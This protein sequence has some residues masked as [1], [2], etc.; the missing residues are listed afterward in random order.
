[1]QEWYLRSRPD[2]ARSGAY[3][4]HGDA[5]ARGAGLRPYLLGCRDKIATAK[6]RRTEAERL[7]HRGDRE[8]LDRRAIDEHGEDCAR[9]QTPE[10]NRI[11]ELR[12]RTIQR[13]RNDRHSHPPLFVPETIPRGAALSTSCDYSHSMV[14]GGFDDTS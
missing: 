9:R 12:E 6:G 10:G 1:M 4:A 2:S 8:G 13:G 11:R 7:N 5:R 3:R 14:A